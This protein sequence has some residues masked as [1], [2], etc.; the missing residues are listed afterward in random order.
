MRLVIGERHHSHRHIVSD[1]GGNFQIAEHQSHETPPVFIGYKAVGDIALLKTV[2]ITG[3]YIG[4]EGVS[5]KAL[6]GFCLSE[7]ETRP[8]AVYPDRHRRFFYRRLVHRANIVIRMIR[9][10]IITV[11]ISLIKF[12]GDR[13]PVSLPFIFPPDQAADG[14]V[15]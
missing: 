11:I 14:Y 13:L 1:I 2:Q 10:E 5:V 4:F 15:G 8:S 6:I 7:G 9:K 3:E 12:I